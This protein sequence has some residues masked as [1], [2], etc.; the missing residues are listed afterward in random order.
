MEIREQG[1]TDAG[2]VGIGT[3]GNPNNV[4]VTNEEI[5]RLREELGI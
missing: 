3:Y 1:G 2:Y 4:V 5:N